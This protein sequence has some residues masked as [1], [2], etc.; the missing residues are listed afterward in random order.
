[1]ILVIL[2]ICIVAF[3]LCLMIA[4]KSYEWG[5]FFG[6]LAVGVGVV[7]ITA[8]VGTIVLTC[9]VI[10]ASV[11]DERIAMYE[12]ENTEIEEQIAS[13]VQQYQ[14]YESGIFREVAPD[15]S[16]TMVSLYPE[17]KADTLVQKQIEIYVANNEKIKSLKEEQITASVK[18]WWL[19]FGK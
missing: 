9:C 13:V 15:S 16:V 12:S 18:R 6:G 8:L 4:E 5:D 7:G 2:A 11:V 3:A 10:D 14:E 1:M 17:L 19:Y